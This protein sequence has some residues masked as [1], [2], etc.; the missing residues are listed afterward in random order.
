MAPEQPLP[1]HFPAIVEDQH[2]EDLAV[3][4][5]LRRRGR[6][7]KTRP[8]TESVATGTPSV[9]PKVTSTGTPCRICGIDDGDERVQRDLH[10]RC[11]DKAAT[12]AKRKDKTLLHARPLNHEQLVERLAR[13]RAHHHDDQAAEPEQLDADDIITTD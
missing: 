11:L 9:A 2:K 1:E 10:R 6:P 13:D 12:L 3:L 4:A 8:A 7:R 5:A